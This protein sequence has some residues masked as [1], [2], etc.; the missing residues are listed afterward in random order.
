MVYPFLLQTSVAKGISSPNA[1]NSEVWPGEFGSDADA[2]HQPGLI[3]S[4]FN[5]RTVYLSLT[6]PPPDISPAPPIL[7]LNVLPSSIVYHGEPDLMREG[8]RPNIMTRLI[9][10]FGAA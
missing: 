7:H 9:R 6:G 3:L 10:G 8:V 2:F 1:G 5:H 4:T